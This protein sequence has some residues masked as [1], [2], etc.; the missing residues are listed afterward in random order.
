VPGLKQYNAEFYIIT[1]LYKA[2][3]IMFEVTPRKPGVYNLSTSFRHIACHHPFT[4]T[5]EAASCLLAYL[6]S[7]ASRSCTLVFVRSFNRVV[8]MKSCPPCHASLIEVMFPLSL[9]FALHHRTCGTSI[10]PTAMFDCRI[11]GCCHI[12]LRCLRRAM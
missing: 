12:A 7:S 11:Q 4:S 1:H 6:C 9:V 8:L 10:S 5:V 2:A 3:S